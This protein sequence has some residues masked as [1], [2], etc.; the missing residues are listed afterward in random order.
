MIVILKDTLQSFLGN[1]NLALG[2]SIAIVTV[3][4]LLAGYAANYVTKRF[5]VEYL[6]AVITRFSS[7]WGTALVKYKVID[8][9]SH[10]APAIIIYLSATLF[11]I[12]EIPATASLVIVIKKFTQ[13]CMLVVLAMV[14]EAF[15]NSI[16]YV[17]NY[18]NVAKKM[19][20][21]SYL[22]VIKLILFVLVVILIVA[23]ILDKSPLAFLTGL[24]AMITVL[25]FV[26][27]DSILGFVTSV[28]LAAYDM[29]RIGD[30]IEMPSYG[31]DG[32][33]IDISL[34]TVKIR[35]FDK[36]ITTVPT[37]TLVS[38]G[39]KN[40]RGMKES[41]GR[42][43]KRS[44]ML[45]MKKI[46]FCSPELLNKLSEIRLIKDYI[47]NKK[48][49]LERHQL[50]LDGDNNQ[51]SEQRRLTNIGCF[52]AYINA[53]LRHNS[54]IHTEDGYTFLVRQL[55]PTDKGLP[56]QLYI[57]CKNTN[58]VSYEEIQS[59]IFDHLLSIL[60]EFELQ[61]YQSV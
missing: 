53:Y 29:V 41:G 4:V 38:S 52:R 12:S 30:W 7:R 28:Q 23:L 3:T 47:N 8:R 24:G 42:R 59:D 25:L 1:E 20:I 17:Y 15:V 13:V 35:N 21:R 39:V 33:V 10:L 2:L 49:E 34:N 19:P 32:T 55:E 9:F 26:F 27:K 14:A 57:F 31:V 56:L 44:I 48:E 46:N 22:Q 58:W 18:Y 54:N 37:H 50:Q 40:W 61:I 11:D 5:L 36:T 6:R 45:D 51:V 16:D 60:P 43:I